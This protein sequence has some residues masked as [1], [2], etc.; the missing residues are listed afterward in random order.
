MCLES[1]QSQQQELQTFCFVLPVNVAGTELRR[2]IQTRCGCDEYANA[3]F[4]DYS[5]LGIQIP[6]TLR[7]FIFTTFDVLKGFK[8]IYN[9]HTMYIET[10]IFIFFFIPTEILKLQFCIVTSS[11]FIKQTVHHSHEIFSKIN[12]VIHLM[13]LFTW[14]LYPARRELCAHRILFNCQVM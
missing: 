3:S 10:N 5:S 12:I 13:C 4:F 7:N 2:K 8:S 11:I 14:K 9:I 1:L 6:L